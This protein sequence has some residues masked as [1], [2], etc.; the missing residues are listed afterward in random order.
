MNIPLGGAVLSGH[1]V[2]RKWLLA[3][4][5]VGKS[6]ILPGCAGT[7]N[8]PPP[9]SPPPSSPPPSSPQLL[10]D[11]GIRSATDVSLDTT[12]TPG[13]RKL[14]FKAVTSNQGAGPL[15][16]VG[17]RSSTSNPTMTSQ[18][19]VY[20]ADRTSFLRPTAAVFYFAGDGHHHWHVRDIDRFTLNSKS[21][22]VE[23][24]TGEKHGFCFEDNTGFR[25]WPGNP[26]HPASP[27]NPVYVPPAA[28]GLN[29]P[30]A[31][32]VIQGLSVGW[33]D[34]YP[35]T[36]PDQYIDVTGLP[37]GVYRLRQTADWDNWFVETNENNNGAWSDISITSTTATIID[38]GG[39]I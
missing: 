35:P 30:D 6:V 2:S 24:R 28:C 21:S 25:G 38:S 34:T 18:Q 3:N 26:S 33:G 39:G 15:E 10:P 22:D 7:P 29:Q 12:T 4:A 14:R 17:N 23:L 37:N 19:K 31:L 36:L 27:A 20:R 1:G 11:L 5:A 8:S 32:N 16:I 13:V 9:S